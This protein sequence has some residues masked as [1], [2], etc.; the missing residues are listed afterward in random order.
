MDNFFEIW[1]RWSDLAADL[2]LPYSTVRSWAD[3]GIPSRRFAQI[4][5]A[6]RA[7]GHDLSFETLVKLS[8]DMRMESVS[9]KSGNAA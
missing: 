5:K 6:A 9:E 1:P 8:D 3:R 7:K 4:V 2:G